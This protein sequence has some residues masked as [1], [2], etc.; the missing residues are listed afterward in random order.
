MVTS[1]H[2]TCMPCTCV[3]AINTMYPGPHLGGGGGGR[4]GHSPPLGDLLPPLADLLPP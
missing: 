4:G 1:M 2:E 3:Q